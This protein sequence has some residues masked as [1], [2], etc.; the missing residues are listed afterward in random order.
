M[1]AERKLEKIKALF[2]SIETEI[3]EC[4]KLLRGEKIE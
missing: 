1:S 2:A 3:L 4:K